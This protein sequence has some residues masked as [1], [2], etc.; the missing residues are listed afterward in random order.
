[1]PSTVFS[2]ADYYEDIDD[3]LATLKQRGYQSV[4][5]WGCST[6]GLSLTRYLLRRERRD[7]ATRRAHAATHATII[8]VVLDAPLLAF[9]SRKL[10]GSEGRAPNPMPP[11]PTPCHRP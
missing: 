6:G 8:A 2:L 3:A 11:V 4:L 5:L 9:H 10:P 1:M 7:T